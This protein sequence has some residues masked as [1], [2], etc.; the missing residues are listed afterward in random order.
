MLG[1][2]DCFLSAHP[3]FNRQGSLGHATVGIEYVI[4]QPVRQEAENF[5]DYGFGWI[6]LAELLEGLHFL[7]KGPMGAE[8]VLKV[9]ML[10]QHPI[11]DG[12]LFGKMEQDILGKLI[13]NLRH[14]QFIGT[15]SK[16]SSQA[17]K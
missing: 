1:L 14:G 8:M 7:D 4:R 5:T 13:K 17:I 12:F 2:F 16:V 10:T 11:P 15:I 9:Q 6:C 3:R